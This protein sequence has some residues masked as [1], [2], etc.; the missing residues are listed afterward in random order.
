MTR[1]KKQELEQSWILSCTPGRPAL[2]QTA[3]VIGKSPFCT[4]CE[5]GAHY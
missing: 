5:G 3:A 2:V 1:G 4:G